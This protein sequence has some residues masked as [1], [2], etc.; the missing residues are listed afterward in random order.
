MPVKRGDITIH[1]PRI[2]HGSQGNQTDGWR[3]NYMLTFSSQE[4]V[5]ARVA[6]GYVNRSLKVVEHVEVCIIMQGEGERVTLL[7]DAKHT[8]T[9]R[10]STV[11]T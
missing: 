2:V 9:I 1:G 11:T 3:R 10:F 5:A 6:A 8:N 7:F 4:A